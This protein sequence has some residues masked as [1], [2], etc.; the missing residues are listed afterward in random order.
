ML[1]DFDASKTSAS[2]ILLASCSPV[3][4]HMLTGS[5][6]EGGK[7]RRNRDRR[8]R[9]SDVLTVGKSRFSRT[10]RSAFSG[11]ALKAIVAFSITI[12]VSAFAS[13]SVELMIEV[14]EA[15]EYYDIALLG[16]KA[17]SHLKS[18]AAVKPADACHICSLC[19]Q[20]GR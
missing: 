10:V 18:R 13:A 9:N 20:C 7:R 4:L 15:S 16:M 17:S 6:A 8:N 14:L 2:A 3:F 12:N 11:E 1:S 19:G 5:F